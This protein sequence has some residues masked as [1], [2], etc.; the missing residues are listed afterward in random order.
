MKLL[1]AA[2]TITGAS[3]S[4]TFRDTLTTL[5]D[6]TTTKYV[7]AAVNE[8]W[9]SDASYSGTASDYYNL[10]TAENSCKF[11]AIQHT[12]GSFDFSSCDQVQKF[13]EDNS[14]A[15]RGHNTCW[16]VNNPSWL[17]NGNFT[18]PELVDILENHVTT[19]LKYYKGKAVAWD[20]V[21]EA[22]SDAAPYDLKLNT[23][24]NITADEVNTNYVDVAFRAA[25]QADPD[26]KLFYNDYNVASS[27]GWSQGKSDAMYNMVK[28]MLDRGVPIDGVGLQMHVG[29]GYDLVDGV[30][31]N[32]ERYGD[33]GLEVHITELDLVCSQKNGYDCVW[34]DDMEKQ[35]GE[36]YATLLQ[37]CLDTEACT[38]FETWGFTDAHSWLE[39]GTHPLPFD[40]NY[41]QKKAVGS[42][43]DTLAGY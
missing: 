3:G 41:D 10:V 23:W 11:S 24:N 27:Q 4:D 40:E 31:A 25:R 21:N 30:K 2:L 13:A 14:M 22:I 5:G 20:V 1:L 15:F 37:A 36:L 16:G 12:Q 35:Q 7:G 32:M 19:V 38:N 34:S 18:S 39:D 8:G 17:D 29:T 43:L 28:S 26:A 9:F 33:L 42:M 6:K